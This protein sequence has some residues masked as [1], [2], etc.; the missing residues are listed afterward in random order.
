MTLKMRVDVATP[1]SPVPATAGSSATV[2]VLTRSL[3]VAMALPSFVEKA[4]AAASSAKTNRS[5]SMPN[6][7]GAWSSCVRR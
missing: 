4:L 6:V 3:Q 1:P 2:A 7:L 5:E